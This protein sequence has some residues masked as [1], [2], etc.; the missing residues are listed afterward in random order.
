MI[1]E[2]QITAFIGAT[3]IFGAFALAH[4][5]FPSD[6]SWYWI[7]GWAFY[8]VRFL[9][10]I[11]QTIGWQA[12]MLEFG[13]NVATATSAILILLAVVQ[14]ADWQQP[15]ETVVSVLW[16]ALI[17]WAAVAIVFDFTF[18]VTYTPLYVAFGGIHLVT[19]Y[20]FYQY[21][22]Q[23]SYSSSPLLIGSLVIWG[24]HKMDY[25]LLRPIDALAPYG[26]ILGALLSFTT[27]LGVMMFLL[28]EA[29]REAANERN[30]ANRRYEE[31]EE[32]FNN[33]PDP[34]YIHDL[35][36][37][38]LKVN[39]TAIDVLGYSRDE[40]ASMTPVDIVAPEQVD[41]I[42]SRIDIA[43]TEHSASFDSA[44]VTAG[45]RTIDVSVNAEKISYQGQDAILAVAR[46]VTERKELEQSLSV[47]N[48][49]L[50]HDIRSAVN[51]IE[52]NAK[53][54]RQ[55]PEAADEPLET[56]IKEVR[57]LYG[58][59]ETAQKIEQ[60]LTAG[61]AKTKVV[62]IVP[63]IESSVSAIQQSHPSVSVDN[64]LSGEIRAEVAVGFEEAI[65]NVLENAI[66]HNDADEPK[67]WIDASR[68]NETVEIQI[69][70][71]G[72][73][74]PNDE[75]EPINAGRET[76]LHHTSGLGLWLVYWMTKESGGRLEISQNE[77]RGTIVTL[78]VPTA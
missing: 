51:V 78:C 48:R 77:P 70:D 61:E 12:W 25:P 69:A 18:V 47:V 31:Y 8:V 30:A 58:I 24:I 64:T 35:D 59:G 32:L 10:D 16:V 1:L 62:D 13:A 2:A 23:Y 72:P 36:G 53:L 26:Y 45:G 43:A 66:V 9:F 39:D 56:V 20:L 5:R 55:S 65:E 75:I 21:L 73:G 57:R 22:K 38:F 34:V 74:I 28:E 40:F 6:F 19:A 11:F 29:E 14:L 33:I 54:A 27:G 42:E 60:L 76:A 41:E 63:M 68:N 71:N 50:R 49:I 44:H 37:N 15:T 67:I 52:G 4:H 7:A 3:L 17:G 46:N